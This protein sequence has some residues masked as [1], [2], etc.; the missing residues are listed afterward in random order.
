MRCAICSIGR[1]DGRD[2]LDRAARPLDVPPRRHL[3]GGT[4]GASKPCRASSR[5]STR[6]R[7]NAWLGFERRASAPIFPGSR[8]AFKGATINKSQLEQIR[9]VAAVRLGRVVAVEPGEI[10]LQQARLPIAPGPVVATTAVLKP[11]P[12]NCSATTS[13]MMHSRSAPTASGSARR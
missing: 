6:R 4:N 2:H 13:E 8:R 3:A 9:S 1:L 10:I 12:T 11:L 7:T 5:R